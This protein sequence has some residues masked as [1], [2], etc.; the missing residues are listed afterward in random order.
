MIRQCVEPDRMTDKRVT[1]EMASGALSI[2][3]H[4]SHRATLVKL[5]LQV[6]CMEFQWPQLYTISLKMASSPSLLCFVASDV[7][8]RDKLL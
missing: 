4:I 6:H 1:V 8:G 2:S 5:G 7:N 3:Y